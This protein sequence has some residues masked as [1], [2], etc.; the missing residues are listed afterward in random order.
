MKKLTQSIL[1]L[2]VLATLLLAIACGGGGKKVQLTEKGKLLTSITWKL[3]P[4][5]TLEGVTD[6]LKDT[7]GITADIKLEGDVKKLANFAAETL[8]LGIDDK[9]P[10]KLS[11]SKTYGEGFLSTSIVGYWHF[12]AD[13]TAIVQREWDKEAGKEKD[14][15]VYKIVELTDKKLVLQKEGDMAPNI[16]FPKK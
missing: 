5:A 10:S 2:V 13:E 11:Y 1:S 9:D 4:S 12:N 7:S 3:D 6:N 14:S 8:V 15:V 16:Y